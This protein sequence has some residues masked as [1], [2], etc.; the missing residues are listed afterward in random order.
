V[1]NNYIYAFSPEDAAEKAKTAANLKM[2]IIGIEAEWGDTDL[3]DLFPSVDESLSHHGKFSDLPPPCTRWDLYGKYK[4]NT[5]FIFS[6]FD[7]DSI[8]GCWILEGRI[9]DCKDMRDLTDHVAW[10]DV[11]GG[12]R[13]HEDYDN[14]VKWNSLLANMNSYLKKLKKEKKESEQIINEMF[15]HFKNIYDTCDL[16]KNHKNYE[17]INREAYNALDKTYSIPNKLH[18]FMSYTNYLNRY[19]IEYRDFVSISEVNIFYDTKKKR[20]SIATYNEEIAKKYFGEK[21]V[22]KLL[23]KYFGKESGGR[24]TVGG[25]PKNQEISFTNFIKFVR[26]VKKIIEGNT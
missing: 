15:S 11:N 23:Q 21:G 22:I 17:Y 14:Y 7:L 3:K 24:V 25:S 8:F 10:C 26:E 5:T 9:D 13:A 4:N 2:H 12:H 20:V 16:T 19:F 6:H 1:K 18:V